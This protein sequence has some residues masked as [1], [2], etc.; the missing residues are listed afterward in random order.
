MEHR[1]AQLLGQGP[2][3]LTPGE[4]CRASSRWAAP[5]GKRVFRAAL[6]CLD[7]GQTW[8]MIMEVGGQAARPA[9]RV[10]Q[11]AASPEALLVGGDLRLSCFSAVMSSIRLRVNQVWSSSLSLEICTRLHTRCPSW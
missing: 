11:P 9:P 8:P 10:R 4:S 1:D 5:R 3:G 7:Q 2:G 6:F